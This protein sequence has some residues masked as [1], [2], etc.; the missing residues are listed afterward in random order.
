MDGCDWWTPKLY[1]GER[2][3]TLG[4]RQNGRHFADDV[5]KCIFLNENVWISLRISLNFVR[6]VPINN[7]PTLVQ[8][9]A[10]RR[11]GAK[12]LSEPMMVRLLTQM[13]VTR[14]QW[15][16][17][18]SRQCIHYLFLTRHDKLFNDEKKLAPSPWRHNERDGV[19]NHRRLNCFLNRFFTH[20]SKKTSKLRVTGLCEGNS[21]VTGEFLA[22]RASNAENV[23]IWWRHHPRTLTRC[24]TRSADHVTIDYTKLC[25]T[26]EL[27]RKLVKSYI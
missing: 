26:W 1:P 17:S 5:F 9:M 10:W 14:P 24:L 6:K 19:T 4:S 15:V 27:W 12:P 20:R 11:S 16:N 2:I 8:I 3:N 7:I 25:A 21:P 18:S 22:Q 13:C 23:S